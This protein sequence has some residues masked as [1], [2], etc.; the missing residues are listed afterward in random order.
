MPDWLAFYDISKVSSTEWWATGKRM[1]GEYAFLHYKDGTYTIVQPAGEDVQALSMLPDGSGFAR[2][3]GSLLRLTKLVTQTIEPGSPG[4]LV[5]TGTEGLTTTLSVPAGAVTDT[6]TLVFTPL[7]T[8]TAP[9]KLA[10]AGHAFE[11][12]AYRGNTLVP[13][14]HFSEPVTITLHY[15]DADVAGLDENRLGLYS[16]NGSTWQ[17]AACGAYDRHPGENWLAVPICHLTQ[18]A[19]FENTEYKVY[20]PIA[21]KQ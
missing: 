19:L 18:F 11:L 2:G 8:I 3:V 7:V 20:L 4:T 6:V 16:L 13:G 15:S 5:Y 17:D 12:D 10:F 21:M 14:F 9:G 1:T